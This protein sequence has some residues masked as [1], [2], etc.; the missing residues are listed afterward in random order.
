MLFFDVTSALSIFISDFIFWFLTVIFVRR[1][2]GN[3]IVSAMI[4]AGLTN[5]SDFVSKYFAPRYFNNIIVAFLAAAIGT[6]CAMLVDKWRKKI[7]Q[8]NS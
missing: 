1:C 7:K 5:S 8:T 3:L 6:G 4:V 2:N